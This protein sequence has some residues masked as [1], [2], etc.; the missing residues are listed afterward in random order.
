MPLFADNC[1]H[2]W[3]LVVYWLLTAILLLLYVKNNDNRGVARELGPAEL[4][5]TVKVYTC[6]GHGA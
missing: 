5:Y 4:L 1:P 2:L 6:H 3:P